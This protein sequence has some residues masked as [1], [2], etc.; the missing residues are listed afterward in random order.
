MHSRVKTRPL[1]LKA[2]TVYK[3]KPFQ[4]DTVSVYD[5]MIKGALVKI[6]VSSFSVYYYH[7][8]IKKTVLYEKQN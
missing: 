1:A 3:L 4:M 8:T 2:G 6:V 7:V 5:S